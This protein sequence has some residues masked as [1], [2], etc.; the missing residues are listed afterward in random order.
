MK[1]YKL[2]IFSH[3]YERDGVFCLYNSLKMTMLFISETYF[4]QYKQLKNGFDYDLNK[5]N[6]FINEL[7]ANELFVLQCK[8]ELLCIRSI[9]ELLSKNLN[10]STMVLQLSDYCNLRCK[11]CFIED[12]I[13]DGY[14]RRKMSWD[15]AKAAIDKFLQITSSSK[16][17]ELT[18]IF[19]GG[20]PL[21]NWAV[22]NKAL[23]YLD[24]TV[25]DK[26]IKKVLITNG[27]LISDEIASA[28]HH[29][30]VE[31]CVSIDGPKDIH[32]SNRVS[33]DGRGSFDTVL[34][35]FKILRKHD[36]EPGVSSVMS[37][38]SLVN[39]ERVADFLFNELHIK[40]IGFNH[41][42]IIP[43]SGEYSQYDIDYEQSYAESLIKMTEIINQK[44]PFV[45]EKR[46]N[47]K[48]NYFL[49]RQLNKASCTGVGL[50]FSVSTDGWIGIC[51]GYM[52]SRKTFNNTVF[53]L[54]YN[55]ANDSVFQEWKKKPIQYE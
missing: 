49:D 6:A 10:I 11:Y 41:V 50:Q 12:G 8:D 42:S 9:G 21:T 55:P 25:I 19:Y 36:I 48:I 7:I 33:E 30:N 51:Q 31:V 34:N 28:L 54:D 39:I 23:D 27:T 17:K 18:V 40:G 2:S 1:K 38:E 43:S 16:K 29:Y 26:V 35:S 20:E 15:V 13:K 46:M 22:L 14:I 32:D 53:N 24:K 44:Y 47:S 4:E 45:Y 52:G 5:N 37:K 3:E